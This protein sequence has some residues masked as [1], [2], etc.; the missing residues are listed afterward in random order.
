VGHQCIAVVEEVRGLPVVGAVEAWCQLASLAS[1]D[2]LIMAGDALLRR[3]QP[4]ARYAD[5]SSAVETAAR[6]RGI[7]RLRT[8]LP[9]VRA[10]TDSP[11]ETVLRLAIIRSGLPEPVVNYAIDVGDKLLHADLAY[12]RHKVA[13]EY[14]GD[15]HRSDVRQYERDIDRLWQIESR[16][17]RVVRINRSHL[18]GGAGQAV[19][20]VRTALQSS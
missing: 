3:H 11:M 17:W 8:A 9:L 13:V 20:R 18:A 5:L 15:Q 4:L 7:R 12:P 10:R 1:E 14:D 6:R 19:A 2:E 16:G